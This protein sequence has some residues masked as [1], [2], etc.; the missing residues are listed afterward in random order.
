MTRPVA[1]ANVRELNSAQTH[2]SSFDPQVARE[3]EL[4]E[5]VLAGEKDTF[6]ELIRPY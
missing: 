1:F 3:R 2:L 4:I 5:R 6:Y